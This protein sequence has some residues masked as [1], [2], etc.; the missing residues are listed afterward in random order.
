ML[1]SLFCVDKKDSLELRL[2]NRDAHL[3]Y[4]GQQSERIRF[5]GPLLADDEETMIGSLLIVEFETRDDAIQFADDD[6]YTQAG[7]FESVAISP[8]KLLIENPGNK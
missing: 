2:A 4:V 6:P 3:A 8:F 7:L 5:A 1:Y